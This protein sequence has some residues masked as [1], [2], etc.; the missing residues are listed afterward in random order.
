MDLADFSKQAA[1]SDAAA[2]AAVAAAAGGGE[3]Y[4]NDPYAQHASLEE[5]ADVAGSPDYGAEPEAKRPKRALEPPAWHA[6]TAPA[7]VGHKKR[8][9]TADGCGCIIHH[10]YVA[11]NARTS[12]AAGARGPPTSP[13]HTQSGARAQNEGRQDGLRARLER[14][15][16]LPRDAA[17]RGVRAG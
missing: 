10:G 14:H 11:R 2:A 12:R 7:P 4:V 9:C 15:R 6:F 5:G 1:D 13:R 3:E 8:V 17:R 16:R